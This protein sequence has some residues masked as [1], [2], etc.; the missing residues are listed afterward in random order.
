MLVCRASVI[1]R[2]WAAAVGSCAIVGETIAVCLTRRVQRRKCTKVFAT[3][4]RRTVGTRSTGLQCVRQ[5]AHL[6]FTNLRGAIVCAQT[7]VTGCTNGTEVAFTHVAE[8]VSFHSATAVRSATPAGSVRVA[9]EAVTIAVR[10][11]S[12][13]REPS[14]ARLGSGVAFPAQTICR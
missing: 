11:T 1:H 8:A 9:V 6:I 2:A 12:E 10:Q 13:S 5:L 4:L 14:G 3:N 7:S